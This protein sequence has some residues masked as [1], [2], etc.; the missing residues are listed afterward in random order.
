MSGA[1]DR[2]GDSLV[3]ASE[4]L[5]MA[6]GSRTR[7]AD[8]PPAWSWALLVARAAQRLR[9]HPRRALTGVVVIGALS[10]AGS[11]LFGPQ[12]NPRAI[13][14]IECGHTVVSSA[15]GDP[16][17]DCAALW[18]SL[19][20]EPAPSLTAWVASSG[21]AVVVVPA[22]APPAGG[23][24]FHWRRLPVGWTQ[25]RAAVLLSH[26]LE[27]ISTG[28][29]A[30]ACWAEGSVE[31]LVRSTLRADGLGS[32][33]IDVR[34]QPSEGATPTCLTVAPIVQS[35]ARSVL[36]IERVVQAPAHDSFRTPA[37]AAELRRVAN[38]ERQV[39]LEAASAKCADV[40][41]AAA[42]WRTYTEQAG[43]PADRYVLVAWPD[44]VSPDGCTHIYVTAPGGG[45]PYNVYVVG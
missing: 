17:S 27:D 28:L 16:V 18:P 15:T 9:R 12:G 44:A 32:W 23:E 33:Q 10:A 11:T 37:G 45:G 14:S 31:A 5:Y 6:G 30:R 26:Q 13:L 7:R 29:A 22:G 24:V 41:K 20:R 35:D 36:L 34:R 25:D 1:L 19:Y 43:L 4:D 3:R 8:E 40:S 39:N 2:F 21:G 42:L 38:V